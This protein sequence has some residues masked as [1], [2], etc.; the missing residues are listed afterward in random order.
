M[1]AKHQQ[2]GPA[3]TVLLTALNHRS[4]ELSNSGRELPSC[5][6]EFWFL[7]EIYQS[8]L[9]YDLRKSV[10]EAVGWEAVMRVR[11]SKD[12]KITR[13]HGHFNFRGK[14]VSES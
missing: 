1:Q 12:W 9:T 4:A 8:K 3:V 14:N 10:S 13:Y 7:T 5:L 2:F 11:C 6:L